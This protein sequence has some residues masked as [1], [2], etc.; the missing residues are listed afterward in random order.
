MAV[1]WTAAWA[2]AVI[3]AIRV[4]AV[5]VC[6]NHMACMVFVAG[7]LPVC[8]AATAVHDRQTAGV[9]LT[10]IVAV[11]RPGSPG[12]CGRLAEGLGVRLA[13]RTGGLTVEVTLVVAVGVGV[14]LA[15]AVGELSAAV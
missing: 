5:R 7:R 2:V 15:S 8:V 10:A 3:S 14:E 12:V 11:L 9:P 6:S 4:G 13:V 1:N